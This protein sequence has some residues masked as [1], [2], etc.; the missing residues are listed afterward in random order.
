MSEIHGF[1]CDACGSIIVSGKRYKGASKEQTISNG[2]AEY[3]YRFDFCDDC[4]R[5]I[6]EYLKTKKGESK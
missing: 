3:S 4:L 6:M 2:S 5:N 1:K